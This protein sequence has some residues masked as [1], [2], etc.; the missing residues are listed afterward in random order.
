[1]NNNEDIWKEFD[2]KFSDSSSFCS[3]GECDLYD[4]FSEGIK[5]LKSFIKSHF[6]YRK[7]LISDIAKLYKPTGQEKGYDAEY[8]EVNMIASFN[9]GLSAVQDLIQSR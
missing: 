8:S 7:T 3:C 1:M 9:A 4:R 2:E 6:L 5:E